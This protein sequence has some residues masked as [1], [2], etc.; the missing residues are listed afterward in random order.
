MSHQVVSAPKQWGLRAC[1]SSGRWQIDV[2]ETHEGNE[3]A[4]QLESSQVYFRFAIPSLQVVAKLLAYLQGNGQDQANGITLGCLGS[5]AVAIL[6][7]TEFTTRWFIKVDA[8]AGGLLQ[9]TLDEADVRML[10]DA[11]QQALQQMQ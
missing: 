1:G 7:D 5:S 11:L 6:R 10:I 9:V 2:D 4:L 8:E 3:W